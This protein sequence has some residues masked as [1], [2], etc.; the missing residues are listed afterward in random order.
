MGQE[1]VV[2]Q[3][4]PYQVE[5]V[6][7]KSYWYCKC[8]RSKRQPFCAG[9]HKN[10]GIE[11]LQFK[12]PSSGTYNLCGCKGTDE[13][14]DGDGSQNVLETKRYTSKHQRVSLPL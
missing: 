12:P 3:K 8:G 9:A 2:A 1:P 13:E 5:L 4:G 11:P 6:E 10:T 14:P 7:G